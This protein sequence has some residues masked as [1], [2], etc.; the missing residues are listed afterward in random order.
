MRENVTVY[1]H[2]KYQRV[3]KLEKRKHVM[4]GQGS[5]NLG[6]HSS[7]YGDSRAE[8]RVR[9]LLRGGVHLF[10]GKSLPVVSYQRTVSISRGVTAVARTQYDIGLNKREVPIVFPVLGL[11]WQ[12]KFSLSRHPLSCGPLIGQ[13]SR[14][15]G[16]N[17]SW[18][19][20]PF[21]KGRNKWKARGKAIL[22]KVVTENLHTS[23]PL[24]AL[25]KCVPHTSLRGTTNT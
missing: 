2:G 13:C 17:S 25:N 12:C 10:R 9:G 24:T 20:L 16:S 4:F 19:C 21:C 15:S 11:V 1:Q 6:A 18:P 3:R 22:L 14:L 5:L 7:S 8:G 23:L